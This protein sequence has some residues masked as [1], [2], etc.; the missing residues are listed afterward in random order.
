MLAATGSATSQT[1]PGAAR[2]VLGMLLAVSCACRTVEAVF[3]NPNNHKCFPGDCGATGGFC[4][5][6]AQCTMFDDCCESKSRPDAQHCDGSGRGGRAAGRR[7][8]CGRATL[9]SV[10]TTRACACSWRMTAPART[11]AAP[12]RASAGATTSAPPSM[13]AAGTPRGHREGAAAAVVVC[14]FALPLLLTRERRTAAVARQR[15]HRRLHQSGQRQLHE[16]VRPGVGRVL[17]RLRLQAAGRLL[18]QLRLLLRP[19]RG[20]RRVRRAQQGAAPRRPAARVERNEQQQQRRRRRRQRQAAERGRC[21]DQ[22]PDVEPKLHALVAAGVRRQQQ[23]QGPQAA[24][25][26]ARR[27]ALYNQPR[28]T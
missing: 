17:V 24:L 8:D 19:R 18:P 21:S 1:R 14:S 4:W 23:Q 25:V 3:E 22:R 13:T 28:V 6:N 11:A 10:Q 15:L 27:S 2:A 12:T 9:A 7:A 26:S 20:A 16:Q 5:C